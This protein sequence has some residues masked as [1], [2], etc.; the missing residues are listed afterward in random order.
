MRREYLTKDAATKNYVVE[1]YLIEDEKPFSAQV[2]ELQYIYSHEVKLEDMHL[3]K[4]FLVDSTIHKRPISWKE[5]RTS[6]KHKY[7]EMRMQGIIIRICIQEL[8][9]HRDK[10]MKDQ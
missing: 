6:L 10:K 1:Q 3:P 2:R 7:N 4:Q 8:D 5:Y 9:K